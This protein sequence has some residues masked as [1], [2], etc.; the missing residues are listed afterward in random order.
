MKKIIDH[1]GRLFGLISIVDVLVLAVVAVSVIA[2]NYKHNVVDPKGTSTPNT[3]IT[4]TAQAEYLPDYVAQAIQ[5]G[6]LV[7]DKDQTTG[8]AIGK[9]TSVE[10]LPAT[11][12]RDLPDGTVIQVTSDSRNNVLITVE[13]SGLV[14]DG[15]YAINRIYEIGVNASR[16][17]YTKY[18]LFKSEFVE[19]H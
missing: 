3:T 2:L 4:F 13:G 15:R 10:I 7:Y 11:S 12:T 16:N 8:G 9:I 14:T 17:L 6:D 18:A 5:V 1:N 19:I